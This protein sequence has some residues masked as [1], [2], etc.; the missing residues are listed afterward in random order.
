MTNHN[1]DS[2]SAGATPLAGIEH[3][4]GQ[5]REPLAAPE[6]AQGMPSDTLCWQCSGAYRIV[7]PW[8]PHCGSPN[9]NVYVEAAQLV[10][11]TLATLAK[12]RDA[13][14]ER[15][16]AAEARAKELERLFCESIIRTQRS[17]SGRLMC[18]VEQLLRYFNE[19]KPRAAF[20][21][22]AP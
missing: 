21:E 9:A 7:A 4:R 16:V 14:R 22:S 1:D 10:Q 17:E 8:C 2:A 3:L 5:C 13:E 11:K 12:E 15:A 19:R 20:T 6:R 18:D